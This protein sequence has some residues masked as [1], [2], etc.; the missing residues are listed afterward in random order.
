MRKIIFLLPMV[1]YLYLVG[2]A[3]KN[4]AAPDIVSGTSSSSLPASAKATYC[5]SAQT[6][7]GATT[8]VTAT[9]KYKYRVVTTNGL[10]GISTT[11][12][13]YAE[14]AI[15]DSNLQRIQC[16]ETGAN[17]DI[18]LS[19]PKTSGNYSLY[20][21]SR[22]SNSKINAYILDDTTNQ[23]PHFIKK[24]FSIGSESSISL[25]DITAEADENISSKIEGGA[26]HILKNLYLAND[27]IRTQIGNS[28]WVA[29]KVTV[30]WK[31]GFNPA[32]YFY[33]AN[34][35]GLSFYIAG[36]N[37][38]YLLGGSNGNVKSADTDHFDDSIILH[39]YGHFLE[40][41]YGKANSP[42]GSHNGNFIIDARLAWSEA[43][44]N[45]FQSTSLGGSMG[46]YYI[47]TYGYKSNSSDSTAGIA[48][49]FDLLATPGG[50]T[51]DSP[52]SSGEGVFRELAISRSLYKSEKSASVSFSDI[53]SSF[54]DLKTN[55]E[56]FTNAGRF[57][58]F[59]SAKSSASG[60]ANFSSVMS[61]EK[62][63]TNTSF[64]ATPLATSGTACGQSI[65]ATIDKYYGSSSVPRSNL[66]TSNDSY[67]YDYSGGNETLKI[68]Y[69]TTNKPG[70]AL[71]VDLDLYLYKASHAYIEDYYL[72]SSI[73]PNPSDTTD[74]TCAIAKYSRTL[75]TGSGE[76]ENFSLAGLASGKY[77]LV[78]KVN[79]YGKT[80]TELGATATYQI[81]KNNGSDV[82]LCPSP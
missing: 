43:W 23:S 25:G 82:M 69:T 73:C 67:R 5:G 53:W 58:Q 32:T 36:T 2:C 49:V 75:N 33:G 70:G 22:S 79:T 39:E 3:N 29:S 81:Y 4:E 63:S 59:L 51:P 13:P 80:S 34:A 20:I 30:Y 35:S 52:G 71:N 37:N 14:V 56:P 10:L 61:S 66:L 55:S 41:N 9:A 6:V 45:Y 26:F 77:L 47:D 19:I 31:A 40:D 44:A 21:I 74:T 48:I 62:Q 65:T 16:A 7:S 72:Q 68:V 38:L 50:S 78:V 28:S 46:Q 76:T 24:D 57:F 18:S 60:N 8:T 27:H 17:G 42:G 12:I 64:Y 15:I 54:T 1:I 11:T